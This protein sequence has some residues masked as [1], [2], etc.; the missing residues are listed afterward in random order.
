[1]KEGINERPSEEPENFSY[2][3]VGGLESDDG[4]ISTSFADE[5]KLNSSEIFGNSTTSQKRSVNRSPSPEKIQDEL[6]E[7]SNVE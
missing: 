1:M 6:R 2:I 5:L 7:R 3:V 4:I